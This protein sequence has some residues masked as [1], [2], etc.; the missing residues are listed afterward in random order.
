MP[1][2]TGKKAN[3]HYN[4]RNEAEM[5]AVTYSSIS[6]HP[7]D[8]R[9]VFGAALIVSGLMILFEQGFHTGFLPILA[10]LAS[11]F[12]LLAAGLRDRRVGYLVGGSIIFGSG[13]GLVA[14]WMGVLGRD[15]LRRIGIGLFGISFGFALTTTILWLA[16]RKFAWWPLIPAGILSSLAIV[17]SFTSVGLLDF[18]LFLGAGMGIVFLA[19]GVYKKLLGLIIPGCLLI[20]ISPGIALAW[21][22]MQGVKVLA[23]TGAMLVWFALGWGLVT[24]V[25]RMVF[26]RFIWWPLIPGGILAVVGWGLY[27]GGNP[28]NAVSFIGN[29]G[30][31]VMIIFGL[32]LLLM[33]RGIRR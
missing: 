20:G 29:T 6:K 30:S 21:G 23:Q 24:F 4:D 17:F 8:W 26:Q 19:V 2:D 31:I 18:I 12:V 1:L 14:F 27:I 10:P 3:S 32:Y 22:G 28:G 25:S 11:G 7:F 33:R 15:P 5:N 13:V 9:I 16:L